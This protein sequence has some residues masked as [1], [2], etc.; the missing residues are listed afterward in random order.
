M[1]LS[2]SKM[3]HSGSDYQWGEMTGD[4]ASDRGK[5]FGYP[6]AAVLFGLILA[7]ATV[8]LGWSYFPS[9]GARLPPTSLQVPDRPTRLY[10]VSDANIRDRATSVG[11]NIVGRLVTGNVVEGV[12]ETGQN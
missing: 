2:H 10:V 6:S 3:V 1:N 12:V 4:K 5:I 8:L 9:G 7:L 11:S